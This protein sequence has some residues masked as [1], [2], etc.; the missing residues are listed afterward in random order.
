VRR[1]IGPIAAQSG[2]FWATA[3]V[4]D[5][6]RGLRYR[7]DAHLDRQPGTRSRPAA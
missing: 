3:V 7:L 1:G 5:H 6:V 2:P 4:R